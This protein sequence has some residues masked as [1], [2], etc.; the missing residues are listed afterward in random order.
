M[1]DRVAELKA[2]HKATEEAFFAH[3]RNCP[4]QCG[5]LYGGYCDEGRALRNE[6]IRAY[7]ELN[8]ATGGAL[9]PACPPVVNER[10]VA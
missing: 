3:S 6:S 8:S 1:S 2:T 7:N 5:S 10:P 4:K 9:G